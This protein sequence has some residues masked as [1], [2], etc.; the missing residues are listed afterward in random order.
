METPE[1]IERKPSEHT[2]A[3]YRIFITVMTSVCTGLA[4]TAVL[5]LAS[6]HN[7]IVDLRIDRATV[8]GQLGSMTRRV[9][10]ISS[11]VNR[12][13]TQLGV[14]NGRVIVLEQNMKVK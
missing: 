3:L 9:D 5:F 4:G 10:D 7:D 13:G 6:M 8:V 1:K 14:L 11:E 12:Q 2:L